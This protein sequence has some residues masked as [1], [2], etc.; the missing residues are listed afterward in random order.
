MRP[1]S[2]D[3][4]SRSPS[5][6]PPG[7]AGV[8]AG[9]SAGIAVVAFLVIP[10]PGGLVVVPFLAAWALALSALSGPDGWK[11]PWRMLLLVGVCALSLGGLASAALAVLVP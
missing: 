7:W 10:W 9:A 11:R 3:P 1:S 2:A 5:C 6:D 8:A 4:R